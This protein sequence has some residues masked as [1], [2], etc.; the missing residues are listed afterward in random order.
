MHIY[1]RVCVVVSIKAIVKVSGN[2]LSFIISAG[3]SVI[4]EQP[5]I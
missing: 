1:R 5:E 4:D 2:D 3:L